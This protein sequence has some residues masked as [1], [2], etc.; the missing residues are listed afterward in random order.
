MD[1]LEPFKVFL[2]EK[3]DFAPNSY[4]VYQAGRLIDYGYTSM[5]IKVQS[6]N[7]STVSQDNILVFIENN[8]LSSILDN[9]ASFDMVMTLH[10]RFIALI[11]PEQ[12]N[13]NDVMFSTFKFAVNCTRKE[14][15]FCDKEPLCM[16]M[17]TENGNVV[18]LSFKV[19]SP[20][21]LI[22]LSI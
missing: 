11:L 7:K 10:D 3:L 4:E 16:S 18:K 22:E 21:T 8:N 6:R 13:I 17:F 19:Y 1:K 9:T 14:K 20:E 15:H 2:L 12:S 5:R